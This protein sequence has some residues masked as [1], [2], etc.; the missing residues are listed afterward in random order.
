MSINL[1]ILRSVAAAVATAVAAVATPENY[2]KCK[3]N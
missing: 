3:R 2:S 1:D